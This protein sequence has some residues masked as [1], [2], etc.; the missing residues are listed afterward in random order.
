[1]DNIS[2]GDKVLCDLGCREIRFIL[3]KD[4]W[5]KDL[6]GKKLVESAITQYKISELI[7]GFICYSLRGFAFRTETKLAHDTVLEF[8]QQH[9]CRT[10]ARRW[11]L[12]D[13]FTR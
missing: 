1:M 7:H 3:R 13:K 2:V 12:R 9:Q 11:V 4:Q 5:E 6:I 10:N 8:P